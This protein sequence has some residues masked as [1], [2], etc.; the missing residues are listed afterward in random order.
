[1][2]ASDAR[3]NRR[4]TPVEAAEIRALLAGLGGYFTALSDFDVQGQHLTHLFEPPTLSGF[5]DRM[6]TAMAESMRCDVGDIPPRVAASSFHLGVAARLLSPAVAAAVIAGAVPELSADSLVWQDTGH[7]FPRFG[8]TGAEWVQA[9]TAVEAAQA[10]ACSV[11]PDVL[12][13]LHQALRATTGLSPTVMSGN[14]VS[15]ANGAVTVLAMSRPHDEG[16]GRA[17]IRALLDTEA[18]AGTAGFERGRFIR[19]S[20][21]LF[22]LAPAGGLCGDCVLAVS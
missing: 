14:V 16:R 11:V 22:Y 7:H 17:L 6:R 3:P 8:L 21:C 9:R 10:I 4:L 12:D 19:R 2:D 13:P 15:A 20:C 18:L 1:M 5:V